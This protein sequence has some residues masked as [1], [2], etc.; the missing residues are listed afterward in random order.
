MTNSQPA[1]L[2]FAAWYV[3]LAVKGWR[4]SGVAFGG[5][6]A[7]LSALALGACGSGPADTAG[8]APGS[9]PVQ[10]T[11]SFPTSQR[12]AQQSDLV[13]T[14]HNTGSQTLPD[15][16]VTLTNPKYGTAAQALGT[17]LA[18]PSPGQPILASRSRPVWIID[19]DPGPC[20]Y[21]CKQGGPGAAA[22]AFSDTWALGKL[23]PGQSAK[24]DWKVTAVRAGSYTVAYKVAAGLSGKAVATGTSSRG[25]LAVKIN[26]APRQTYVNNS[27]QI[28]YGN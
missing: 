27:G 14:V 7:A 18:A 8:E 13:I 11:S 22:T 12:L 5:C 20:Q 26:S 1:F 24:F 25:R 2:C 4:P 9:F 6:A 28:V 10:V 21:S 3:R 23:A 16:A 17:L 15:V 19:Q